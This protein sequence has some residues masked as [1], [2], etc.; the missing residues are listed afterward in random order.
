MLLNQ[1]VF[2]LFPFTAVSL[3]VHTLIIDISFTAPFPFSHV[4][5]LPSRNSLF[6]LSLLSHSSSTVRLGNVSHTAFTATLD[7]RG[8]QSPA[9]GPRFL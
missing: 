6:P 8:L 7:H 2:V 1:I 5:S 3:D 4:I 9:L